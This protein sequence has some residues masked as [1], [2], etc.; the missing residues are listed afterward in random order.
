MNN[1]SRNILISVDLRPIKE[2][3]AFIRDKLDQLKLLVE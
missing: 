1:K 2:K 3:D